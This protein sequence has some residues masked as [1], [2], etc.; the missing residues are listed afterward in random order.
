MPDLIGLLAKGE[1]E[2]DGNVPVPS[3]A[4]NYYLFSRSDGVYLI[5]PDGVITGPFALSTGGDAAAIHDNVDAEISALTEKGTPVIGDWF[6]IE[7]SDDGYSKKKANFDAIPLWGS[8]ISSMYG[9]DIYTGEIYTPVLYYDVGNEEIVWELTPISDDASEVTY[10]PSVLTDWDGDADP[11]HVNGALNQL[12]ERIDDVEGAAGH[13]AVTLDADAAALLD[14]SSQEIGLDTQ[15][16]NTVFAGPATGAANEPTFRALVAAD[17]GT[18]APD[19]TKF[20]RDDMSWQAT[21]A[22]ASVDIIQIQV[23]S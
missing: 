15:T 8:R 18:G 2:T 19:G 12:A 11:G 23:F 1:Y 21:S 20:L 4:Y 10:T 9:A 6:L 5:D 17:V 14:L 22:S 3:G 16:A 13:D 7:D